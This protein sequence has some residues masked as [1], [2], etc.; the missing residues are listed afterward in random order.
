MNEAK[1]T[2]TLLARM[3]DGREYSI[4][5]NMGDPTDG[6]T[7]KMRELIHQSARAVAKTA[8]IALESKVPPER[9]DYSYTLA[10]V[11]QDYLDDVQKKTGIQL[12]GLRGRCPLPPLPDPT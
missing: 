2:M 8:V 11:D 6:V 10:K 3:A 4:V 12:E 7:G 9:W 1:P 5:L